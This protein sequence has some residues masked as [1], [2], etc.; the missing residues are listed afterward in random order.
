[1]KNILVIGGS[2]FVGKV[3]VEE[4]RKHDEYSVYVMNRG[5]RPLNINGVEEIQ[6][7]RHDAL[8]LA[9]SVPELEWDALVDFCAYE[10]DD[11]D[12]LLYNLPGS[13]NH[14]I[15]FST[16]TTC[17]TSLDLPMTEDTPK[18]KGPL[19]G[20]HG[21]YGYKKWLT[22]L[23]LKEVC[24]QKS[25]HHTSIRPAFIYGK[26]N[27]APR[28]SYFFQLIAQNKPFVVPLLP[29]SL[30]TMISVWDVANIVISCMGN[31]N[32]FDNAYNLSAPELISYDKLVGTL[33]KITGR[34]LDL[35]RLPIAR[36]DAERIPL[37]FPLDE[38]L[39]YSGEKIAKALDF[40]YMSFLEGMTRTYNCF[41]G[42]GGA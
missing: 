8:S 6:C 34:Q 36:I 9:A 32:V 7:D 39:V 13:L 12:L 35:Q 30:F 14:Y 20:P 16:T 22:E 25:I 23:K 21:D 40:E 3:F 2:Y 28:E 37:P 5:N 17:E 26:Y 41:F 31:E 15:Y 29:Q 1:M 27:Y 38:H 24:E 18:L 11:I 19:P 33:E 42:L 10:P 4:L